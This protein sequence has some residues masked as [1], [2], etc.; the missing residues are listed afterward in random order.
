MTTSTK[1]S[2]ASKSL[3]TLPKDIHNVLENG[4][5]VDEGHLNTFVEGLRSL[6]RRRLSSEKG[7]EDRATLRMSNIG[8]PCERKLW[9]TVNEPHEAE[10]IDGKTKFKFLYGDLIEELTLFLAR[11]SGHKVTGEQERQ[12]VNGVIGHRDAVI[13][14]VVVDVKS[15]NSRGM[16]KFRDHTLESDDPFGYLPQL[17]LYLQAGQSDPLVDVKGEAAFLVVDKELGGIIVDRYKKDPGFD[18]SKY[19]ASK[20]EMVSEPEPPRRRYMPQADGASGNL[21][22]GMECSYCPFKHHCHP[23]LRGFLY[24]SGPRWLTKVVRTP[25]VP[26]IKRVQKQTRTRTVEST[27]KEAQANEGQGR[28]RE[29]QDTVYGD[30]TS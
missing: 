10:P 23:G 9:Y 8:T 24:S 26:E 20:K 22:L 30:R 18:W 13:D 6:L 15:A 14:G 29:R 2:A 1:G 25:D 11:V 27:A 7:T 3:S 12:E 5:T 28:V 4:T 17:N 16:A 19:V 21:K